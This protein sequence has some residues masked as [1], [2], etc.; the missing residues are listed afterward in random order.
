VGA[1]PKI[2]PAIEP[3]ED[4]RNSISVSNGTAVFDPE[5]W[6]RQLHAAGLTP[7]VLRDMADALVEEE[8]LTADMVSYRK[9]VT[10][11]DN[12]VFISVKFPQHGPRIKVAIDPPTHID[13]AGDNA[14]VS[15]AD[16]SVLA[17]KLSAD[18]VKQVRAFIDLNQDT[19]L[20][21]W[22]KRIDTDELRQRL[23]PVR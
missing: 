8:E 23:Q 18:V 7:Y 9:N 4:F 16:G 11:L 19:L 13:P 3:V 22:E 17:G 15:I 21:Y 12:T 1:V 10:G 5:Q 14:S 20:D 6:L 2:S